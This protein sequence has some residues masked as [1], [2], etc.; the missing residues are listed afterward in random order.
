MTSQVNNQHLITS[1]DVIDT[2]HFDSEDDY[3]TGCRN[4]SHCQQQQSYSKLR[5]PRR[6]S[7]TFLWNDI[8]FCLFMLTCRFPEYILRH[9]EVMSINPSQRLHQ[10]CCLL[11]LSYMITLYGL[12]YQDLKKK[13]ECFGPN[14]THSHTIV[15]FLWCGSLVGSLQS[16]Q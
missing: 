13:G 9:L 12:N 10:S 15:I 14:N 16:Y 8:Y 5:S 2:T 7:S 1:T 3:C 6:S 4:V 11:Y